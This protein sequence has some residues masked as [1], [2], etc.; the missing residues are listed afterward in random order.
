M[1]RLGQR[2][3]QG[4]H[5]HFQ[6][7]PS[8]SPGHQIELF[9]IGERD[10]KSFLAQY[11]PAQPGEIVDQG[12]RVIGTHAGVFYYTP[13]QRAPVGGVK[14]GP[15]GPWFILRK[16]VAH[17]RLVAV[18]GHDHPDLLSSHARTQ[19]AHWIADHPPARVFDAHVQLRH[20]G[21]AHP[22]RISV[23]DNGAVDIAFDQPVRALAAGQRC[24]T[25]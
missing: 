4:A 5:A 13:G 12:G 1:A 15:A 2:Q 9:N 20:L 7:R 19:P 3:A 10:F 8:Q 23:Q 16:E 17:N 6:V 11:L 25:W 21:Q 22:A 24:C 14:Q 18:P